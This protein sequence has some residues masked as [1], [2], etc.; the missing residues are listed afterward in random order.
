[1]R[2]KHRLESSRQLNRRNQNV[3]HVE[4]PIKQK[5]AGTEPTPQTTLENEDTSFNT[6]KP[7]HRPADSHHR[8][9]AKKLKTS[10]LR[11]GETV[12]ARA[13]TIEDPPNRHE[14]DFMTECNEEPM[15]N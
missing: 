13:Y 12:D 8:N 7:D 6:H 1:M 2:S 3:T 4:K 15:Q 11:F 10:R 5:T 9:L 14:E